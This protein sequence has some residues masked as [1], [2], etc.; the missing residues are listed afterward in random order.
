MLLGPSWGSP[1]LPSKG[2]L[3]LDLE[4]AVPIMPLRKPRPG[5]GCLRL[6]RAW[7]GCGARWPQWAPCRGAHGLRAGKAPCGQC[8][9]AA[10]C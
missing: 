4:A 9:P 2:V 5:S 3:E 1:A 6:F 10:S 7:E 8:L